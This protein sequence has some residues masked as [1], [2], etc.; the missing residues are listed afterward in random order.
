MQGRTLHVSTSGIAR[1]D[2]FNLTGS[3]VKTLWN[4]HVGGSIDLGI[5][6]IAGGV[7]VVRMQTQFG[8]IMQ[9]VRFE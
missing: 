1:V 7:Y 2:L 4:G 5:Q 9:K 3:V 8:T 6:G